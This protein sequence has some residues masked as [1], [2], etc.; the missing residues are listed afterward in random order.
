MK[1]NFYNRTTRFLMLV[2]LIPLFTVLTVVFVVSQNNFLWMI[3][4]FFFIMLGVFIYKTFFIKV[5]IDG[6]G[7]QYKSLFQEKYIA[8]E[9]LLDVLVVHKQ[10]RNQPSYIP[11]M[12]WFGKGMYRSGDFVMF[13]TSE[14]MPNT[15]AFVFS[16]PIDRYYICVQYQKKLE[17]WV[18]DLLQK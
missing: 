13:R 15:H 8:K 4:F 1:F 14:E 2:I 18:A 9:E 6:K 12:D 17:P 5:Y 16:A 11:F 3:A 10:R 7:V